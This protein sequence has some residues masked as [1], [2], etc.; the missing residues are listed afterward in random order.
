MNMIRRSSFTDIE[1]FPVI[2]PVRAW[3]RRDWCHGSSRKKSIVS[4]TISWSLLL[5]R[6]NA[7]LKDEENQTFILMHERGEVCS[8]FFTCTE[9]SRYIDSLLCICDHIIEILI[10]GDP[11][12]II[13]L[14]GLSCMLHLSESHRD[15]SR[16]ID[17]RVMSIV[18]SPFF[19]IWIKPDSRRDFIF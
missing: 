6:E 8:N 16:E 13:H 12:R 19:E 10:I 18:S 14:Y 7:L 4:I 1:F 2:E 11:S 15:K 5:S 9:W 17:T 3:L